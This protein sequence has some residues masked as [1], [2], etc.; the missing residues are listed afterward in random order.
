MFLLQPTLRRIATSP[1]PRTHEVEYCD[2]R[3]ARRI[4]F[5]QPKVTKLGDDA[6]RTFD[7]FSAAV[8]TAMVHLLSTVHAKGALKTANHGLARFHQMSSTL[9][10]YITHL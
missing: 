4:W 10:A 8:R 9:L 1:G 2:Q 6:T 5:R 3:E 7:K